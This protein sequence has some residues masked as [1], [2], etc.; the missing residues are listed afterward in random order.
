MTS[1]N[2]QMTQKQLLKILFTFDDEND[3]NIYTQPSIC[4]PSTHSIQKKLEFYI[5]IGAN[6][7]PI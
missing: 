2:D 1:Q 7:V 6:L 4:Y 3:Q 5:F